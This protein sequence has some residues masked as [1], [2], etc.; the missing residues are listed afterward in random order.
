MSL[1]HA[2]KAPPQ[3][4]GDPSDGETEARRYPEQPGSVRGGTY[5]LGLGSRRRR[6]AEGTGGGRRADPPREAS[7]PGDRRPGASV[8]VPGVASVPV[9]GGAAARCPGAGPG[10]VPGDVCPVA[11]VFRSRC[12]CL[13]VPRSRGRCRVPRGR[14]PWGPVPGDAEM[15]VPEGAGAGDAELPVPGDASARD[16]AVP[17]AGGAGAGGAEVP[18]PVPGGARLAPIK[19]SSFRESRGV[20]LLY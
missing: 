20:C 1:A 17:V 19:G 12:R 5:E 6:G 8:P 9:P 16:C 10:A 3:I 18:M 4:L 13:A 7:Q 15:S 14:C 11:G 2:R